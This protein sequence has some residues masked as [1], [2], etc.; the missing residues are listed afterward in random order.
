MQQAQPQQDICKMNFLENFTP[1]DNYLLLENSKA[2]MKGLLKLTMLDLLLK[3]V[4]EMEN[5]AV[6][7]DERSP[8]RI[9]TYVQAGNNFQSYQPKTHE[10]IFLYIFQTNPDNKVLF[11]HFVKISYDKAKSIRNLVYNKILTHSETS[12][13][14]NTRRMF[15]VVDLNEWGRLAKIE[16]QKNLNNLL[17]SINADPSL[18][19]RVNGNLFLI[20][21]V[22]SDFRAEIDHE[23]DNWESKTSSIDIS[24]FFAYYHSFSCD[25]DSSFDSAA[26]SSG[27][28]WFGEWGSDSLTG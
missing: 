23:L 9:L 7:A 28:F 8:E 19:A 21:I 26:S 6:R 22:D 20:D 13:L 1:A 18:L 27:S 17:P 3:R 11:K 5:V 14:F 10:E 4:I 24:R 15:A 2:T 16:L 12:C 25:F